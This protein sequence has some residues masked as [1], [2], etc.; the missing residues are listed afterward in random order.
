LTIPLGLGTKYRI[1]D[2]FEIGLEGVVNMANT[3]KF[4]IYEPVVN[5]GFLDFWG[6]VMVNIGYN[7]TSGVNS[8]HMDWVNP[9]AVIYDDLAKKAQ[10]SVEAAKSDGIPDYLDLEP[11]TKKGCK[12]N[13]KGITL[14]S[15]VDGVLDS[16]DKEPIWLQPNVKC[17]LTSRIFSSKIISKCDEIF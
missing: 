14:D 11:N 4:D 5:Q 3:N 16:E 9:M 13:V 6:S 12:V 17:L 7:F 10:K 1:N 15:D 8:K 2:K